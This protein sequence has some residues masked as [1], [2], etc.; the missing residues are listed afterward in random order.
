MYVVIKVE[1]HE[2]CQLRGD[3]LYVDLPVWE[4]VAL[5]GGDMVVKLFDNKI[6]IKIPKGV[7]S[8]AMLRLRGKGMPILGANRDGDLYCKVVL[9][10]GDGRT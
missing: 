2:Y 5:S 3:D 8:G 1:A 9:L 7:G 6:K 10:G 4:H